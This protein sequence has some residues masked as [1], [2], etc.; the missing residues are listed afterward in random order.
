MSSG[1]SDGKPDAGRQGKGEVAAPQGGGAPATAPDRGKDVA[2]FLAAVKA[3]PQ[4]KPGAGRGRLIFALDA[5]ASRQPTWDRASRLHG[6]MFEAAA[7][8]GGLEIQLLFYRG[9]GECKAS[10]WL[11]DAPSLHRAMGAVSCVGGQ[12]QIGRVLSHAAKAARERPVNA[13][14]FVGDAMEESP[15]EL[16]GLAGELALANVPVFV[17]HEGGEPH[18]ARTFREIARLTRGAYCPFDSSSAQQLR[19][20]L[21]AVATYAAGGRAAL[22][23]YGKRVGGAALLLAN[24]MGAQR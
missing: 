16:S 23:D 8:L 5:T 18:A 20:L 13:L 1:K 12:T 21:R 9:F 14:V 15:D 2:A 24:G 7:A 11:G 3:M 22:L 6:E 10:R 17:F 4:A 19:D